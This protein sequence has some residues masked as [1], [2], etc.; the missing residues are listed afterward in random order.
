MVKIKQITGL[1][2]QLDDKAPATGSAN[3]IQNQS[4]SDQ[5]AD[6]RING[7]GLFGGNIGLGT[8][9]PLSSIDIQAGALTFKNGG[10]NFGSVDFYSMTTGVG[11]GA[12]IEGIR[13][14]NWISGQLSFQTGEGSGNVAERM[15]IT[16]FGKIGIGETTPSAKLHIKSSTASEVLQ[17]IQQ[18]LNG[19][20]NLSEWV[21]SVGDTLASVHKNGGINAG[22]TPAYINTNEIL[23]TATNPR[24]NTGTNLNRSL[25]FAIG[26]GGQYAHGDGILGG[27]DYLGNR[28][29]FLTLRTH[30]TDPTLSVNSNLGISN[31]KAIR[32][33]STDVGATINMFKFSS[34]NELEIGPRY[35]RAY[36]VKNFIGDATVSFK[37]V[38]NVDRWTNLAELTGA[39][40][41]SVLGTLTAIGGNSTNWNTAFGWGDHAAAGYLT[42]IPA[43]THTIANV[44]GLQTE[45]DD[46]DTR[47]TTLETAPVVGSDLTVDAFPPSP[48]NAIQYD[49]ILGQMTFQT[50]GGNLIVNA[51]FVSYP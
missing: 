49:S 36:G 19:T 34:D 13:G 12:R 33:Y 27:M 10:D 42:S 18:P 39:G 23:L 47:I 43:H 8:L 11:M 1:Q 15:R 29:T 30:A 6:F 46:H 50:A 3:Y 16:G 41:F 7:N 24:S 45:L 51:S 4:G 44:T 32:S 35:S 40:N 20:A 28:T 48:I 26:Q 17:K 25:F 22:G 31:N 14:A 9:T 2:T 37:W 38:T 5:A 21:N